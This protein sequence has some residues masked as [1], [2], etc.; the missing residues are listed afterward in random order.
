MVWFD[1]KSSGS[2]QT[3]NE[4]KDQSGIKM[5]YMYKC[6]WVFFLETVREIFLCHKCWEEKRKKVGKKKV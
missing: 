6:Q 1:P 3:M 5:D 2:N 4:M